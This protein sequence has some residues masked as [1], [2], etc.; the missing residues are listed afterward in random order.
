MKPYNESFD[1]RVTLESDRADRGENDID[2]SAN[3][4]LETEISGR[5]NPNVSQHKAR[6]A[7][8]EMNPI[9]RSVR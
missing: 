7:A 5:Y 3:L 2:R 1:G 9:E 8:D 6:E 4:S